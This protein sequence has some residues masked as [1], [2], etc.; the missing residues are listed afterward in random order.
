MDHDGPHCLHSSCHCVQR[1]PPCSRYRA[2]HGSNRRQK[3]SSVAAIVSLPR[4]TT[5]R[6][7]TRADCASAGAHVDLSIAN[8]L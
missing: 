8:H 4:V 7:T 1:A 3:R 5:C 2:S 6:R